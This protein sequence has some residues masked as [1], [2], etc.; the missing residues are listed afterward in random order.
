MLDCLCMLDIHCIIFCICPITQSAAK[1][2][3]QGGCLQ[4]LCAYVNIVLRVVHVVL[5]VHCFSGKINKNGECVQSKSFV[6]W[7]LASI[8]GITK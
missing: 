1:A 7:E 8:D 6:G 3:T 5:L 4:L 2:G